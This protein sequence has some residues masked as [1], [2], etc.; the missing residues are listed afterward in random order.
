MNSANPTKDYCDVVARKVQ[1]ERRRVLQPAERYL[2][3]VAGLPPAPVL[4]SELLSILRSPE[5]DLDRVVELVGCDPALTAQILRASNSACFAG[6]QPT[7]DIFNAVARM[8]LYQVYCMVVAIFGA[9]TKSMP[10]AGQGVNQDELWRHSVAV[11]ISSSIIADEAG[12]PKAVAFTAGL[13]HDI[14]KLVLASAERGA[15]AKLAQMAKDQGEVLS[16][17]E[18][19]LLGIDHAQLGGELMRRWNLPPDVVAAV[20]RHHQLDASP[21][22]EQL[23]AVVQVADRIGHLL[24]GEELPD[25]DPLTSSDAAM[26]TL[27]LSPDDFPRL[28]AKTEADMEKLKGILQI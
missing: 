10:G 25:A 27:Q 28:L 12:Q 6:E 14:G 15:Y 22:L 2:N 24:F 13:L 9:R 3:A 17:L 16:T 21:P 23:T 5:H 8:G 26:D 19:A 7:V 20:A 4:M 11:S 18:R 1:D